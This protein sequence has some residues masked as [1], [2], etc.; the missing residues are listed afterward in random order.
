MKIPVKPADIRPML[1]QL[2]GINPDVGAKER[3]GIG[4]AP[5]MN[6]RIEKRPPAFR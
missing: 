5:W 3:V 2:Q 1:A 6:P 4:S